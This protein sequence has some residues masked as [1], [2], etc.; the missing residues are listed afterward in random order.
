MMASDTL[1]DMFPGKD[2]VRKSFE[3]GIRET[4]LLSDTGSET[5]QM[6]KRFQIQV[7][8]PFVGKSSHILSK[9]LLVQGS[10]YSDL[11]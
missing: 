6:S 7:V 8:S 5:F 9:V 4:F 3:I 11:F 2:L 10:S 1:L